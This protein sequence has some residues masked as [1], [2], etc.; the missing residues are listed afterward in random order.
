MTELLHMKRVSAYLGGPH[1]KLG[2]T[3]TRTER[4]AAA[5]KI[6]RYRAVVWNYALQTATAVIPPAASTG[7]EAP[8]RLI[9]W[10]EKEQPTPEAL[11]G[12]RGVSALELGTVQDIPLVEIWRRLAVASLV[13][14]ERE[15]PVLADKI[16]NDQARVVLRDVAD[17]VRALVILDVRYSAIPGWQRLG[18]K[19]SSHNI[20][21]TKRV[22]VNST[23]AAAQLCSQWV[24]NLSPEDAV[25]TDRLGYVDRAPLLPMPYPFGIDGAIA[26][27]HNTYVRLGLEFPRADVLTAIVRVQRRLSVLALELARA[28]VDEEHTNAFEDRAERCARVLQ[29]LAKDVGGNLGD[30][31]ATMADSQAALFA[32]ADAAQIGDTAST[33]DLQSMNRL[34][35]MID[36]RVATRIRQG[37]HDRRYFVSRELGLSS[38]RVGGVRRAIRK[39]EPITK[40]SHPDLIAA[41]KRLAPHAPS[42]VVSTD[43]LSARTEFTAL[44]GSPEKHRSGRRVSQRTVAPDAARLRGLSGHAGVGGQF[45][46]TSI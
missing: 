34:F 3:T 31:R 41:V 36:K 8:L 21:P 27:L 4:E 32:L 11:P 44:V 13:G 15:L 6:L 43:A 1:G 19:S 5:H 39:Y 40:V 17:L 22:L 24:G 28:A 14:R 26:A 35:T 23:I 33:E 12:G 38:E 2:E 29:P 16:D 37:I 45:E 7:W 9:S 42:G 10:L 18:L 25:R 46:G 30:G 20:D